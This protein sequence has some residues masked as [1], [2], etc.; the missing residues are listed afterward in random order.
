MVSHGQGQLIYYLLTDVQRGLDCSFEILLTFNI[1]EDESFLNLFKSLPIRAIRNNSP[2]GF[3][4]NHNSAFAASRGRH[5]VIVNPDI[6]AG[7][8]FLSPLLRLIELAR[9]GAC[10]PVVLSPS[11]SVED[12]ARRFPSF[13]R[14]TRR[15]MARLC[16]HKRPPEYTWHTTAIGVDW[17]AGMFVLFRRD[18]FLEVGGF[19]E[20]YFMYFEDADICRR[21]RVKGWEIWLCPE[22]TVI[23]D[24]QRASHRSLKH[25]MWHLRSAFLYLTRL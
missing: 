9:V 5:F 16:H 17:L 8:L 20:R 18:A 23:H 13:G 14:L 12:S 2:K 4:A 11:G 3:G 7:A 10:G 24:A 21:L 6:R 22:A 1:P 15:F 25:M 19:D